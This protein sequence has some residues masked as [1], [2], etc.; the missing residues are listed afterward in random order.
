M[1][2]KPTVDPLFLSTFGLTEA[3]LGAMPLADVLEMVLSRGFDLEVYPKT[4]EGEFSISM[5]RRACIRA[6]VLEAEEL[7]LT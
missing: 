6:M 3:E 5:S 4:G 7:G 2:L 1:L